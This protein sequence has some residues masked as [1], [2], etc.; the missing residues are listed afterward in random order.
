MLSTQPSVK[1]ECVAIIPMGQAAEEY[2]WRLAEKLRDKDISIH[3]DFE[4]SLKSRMKK[5]IRK[6][7]LLL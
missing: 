2:A 7:R 4:G 6:K 5:R 3:L 1:K